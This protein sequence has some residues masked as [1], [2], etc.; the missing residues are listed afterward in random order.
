MPAT[1][2]ALP[3]DEMAFRE[4]YRDLLEKRA[5]TTVFRPGNRI[6]PNWRGYMEGEIVTARIIRTPGSD[7]HGVAPQFHDLRI[8]IRIVSLALRPVTL[9][10]SGDFAG[11]SPDVFDRPSLMNHLYEIYGRSIASFGN[12]VTRIGFT[13][14]E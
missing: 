3:R 7:K 12:R 9:L 2:L 1:T 5:L 11:S 8:P 10:E 6:F 14:A 13:H 4:R